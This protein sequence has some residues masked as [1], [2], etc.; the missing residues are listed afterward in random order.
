MMKYS[1]KSWQ[2]RFNRLVVLAAIVC[3]FG[4]ALWWY[5]NRP[6]IADQKVRVAVM[7][8]AGAGPGFVGIEKGLFGELDVEIVVIDDTRARQAAFQSNDFE[9]YLTNPDQH[10]REVENGLPGRMLLLS[11]LSNGADGVIARREVTDIAELKGRRVAYTQGT[12][13]DFM[14]SLALKSAGID[15][16]DLDLV[17]LDDPG[18]AV[19][20][21]QSGDVDAAVSWEPLM[22]EAT[23]QDGIHVLF[24][25]A[26]VPGAIIGVFVA[27]QTLL[28]D[29]K[30][31]E[32]FV[33]GWLASVEYVEAHPKESNA[34]M[35]QAFNVTAED[36]RGMM[37]GLKLADREVQ[38]EY[39]QRAESGL[40][41]LD[42]VTNQAA[43]FWHSIGLLESVP[44]MDHRWVPDG[45]V[46]YYELIR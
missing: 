21:L 13:S 9:V 34:I 37:S 38:K 25:S 22:T 16:K 36:V 14:L 42:L 46:D 45:V 39:F 35:A 44:K 1:H 11:D 6:G 26:D 8:W 20:A 7:T 31:M 18:T 30:R 33:D 32:M 19:A 40:S 23:K 4:A 17:V 10:S 43:V 12:A 41:K 2:R 5:A 24:T 29:S 27:K 28:S 15:R 3:C